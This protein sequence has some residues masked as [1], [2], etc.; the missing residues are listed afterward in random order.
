MGYVYETTNDITGKKYIGGHI[1][2]DT[3]VYFGSG[4]KFVKDFKKYG[5]ECFTRVIL[6]YA[7]NIEHLKELETKWLISVDAKN[8][9]LYYNS[10]NHAH[11]IK[12]TTNDK[13]RP[14]CPTCNSRPVAINRYLGETVYYRKVCDVCARAGKKYKPVPA[15]YKA[16]Y[17][18]LHICDKCGWRA[19][20]PDKQMTV[21]HIDGNLKNVIPFNLKTICLNCRVE[22]AASKLPWKPST[23]V[24]DF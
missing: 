4:S 18:K 21:Y 5:P 7:H 12:H 3:D 24:P 22:V 14:L 2:A 6:E 13:V 9:D 19:K 17:R 11:G 23:I 20:Y 8:N 16:G 15:W 10:T 1:G